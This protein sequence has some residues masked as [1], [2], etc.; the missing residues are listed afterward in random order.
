M[1]LHLLERTM[2]ERNPILVEREKTHGDFRDV[3]RVAQQLKAVLGPR[4]FLNPSQIEAT[5]L[6]CT[7]LARIVCG[8]ANNKD[9][10]DDGAGYFNLGAEACVEKSPVGVN[11]DNLKKFRNLPIASSGSTDISYSGNGGDGTVEWITSDGDKYD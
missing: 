3:A 10:W 9:H 4:D 2:T 6:I 11:K 1:P 7:K 8:D 5:D